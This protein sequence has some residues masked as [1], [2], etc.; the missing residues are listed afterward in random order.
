MSRDW[1]WIADIEIEQTADGTMLMYPAMT[2]HG[3]RGISSTSNASTNVGD[4][5]WGQPA[6]TATAGTTKYS[7]R[8]LLLCGSYG[9]GSSCGIACLYAYYGLAT[10][11]WDCSRPRLVKSQNLKFLSS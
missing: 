8:E 9:H 7:Y 11:N 1:G 5:V 2:C 6:T 3:I 10:G 4:L